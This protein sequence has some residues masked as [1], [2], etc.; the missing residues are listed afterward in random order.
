VEAQV[1]APPRLLSETQVTISESEAMLAASERCPNPKPVL[2]WSLRGERRRAVPHGK[3]RRRAV[4]HGKGPTKYEAS[5]ELVRSYEASY[6]LVR[7][8]RTG[9]SSYELV[10]SF[11]PGAGPT[12][13]FPVIPVK[14]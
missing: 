5:Y 4:P 11:V 8:P 14:S 1:L 13:I 2:G 7:A 6:E 12:R 10:R 3:K 9:T